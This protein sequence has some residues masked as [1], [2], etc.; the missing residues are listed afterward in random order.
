MYH[1]SY[2]SGFELKPNW[3]KGKKIP[4][5]PWPAGTS[6]FPVFPVGL[7][8]AS[9][10]RRCGGGAGPA[11]APPRRRAR[12]P[13][14]RI[15]PGPWVFIKGGGAPPVGPP[16]R[17]HGASAAR[18][19]PAALRGL[20]GGAGE[21]YTR[22]RFLGCSAARSQGIRG[23]A[24]VFARE[25]PRDLR[26]CHREG[27]SGGQG[28]SLRLLPL[29]P[30]TASFPRGSFHTSHSQPASP[31]PLGLRN[32][33]P[34]PPTPA[35][36]WKTAATLPPGSSSARKQVSC[37]APWGL[38]VG[39]SGRSFRLLPRWPAPEVPTAQPPSAPAA[40]GP[41]PAP[42]AEARRPAAS[43]AAAP[44]PGWRQDNSLYSGAV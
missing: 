7:V 32:P 10:G 6:A 20:P 21:R 14:P 4:A 42:P 26:G 41:R 15:E 17:G 11:A 34:S 28:R 3:P 8:G 38:P 33:I 39:A 37:P 13:P 12:R 30:T 27:A 35:S 43:T 25:Q 16:G 19:N 36:M 2:D 5:L 44:R 29:T 22:C 1:D 9:P 31:F 18:P 24:T 23:V 40:Q